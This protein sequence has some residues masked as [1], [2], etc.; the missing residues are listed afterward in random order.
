MNKQDISHTNG[1][2]TFSLQKYA[3]LVK[4]DEPH[5]LKPLKTREL[6]YR[7]LNK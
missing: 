5:Y 1:E 3:Q 6:L 4:P 7:I 2:I